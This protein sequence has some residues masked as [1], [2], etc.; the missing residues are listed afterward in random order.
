MLRFAEFCLVW[1]HFAIFCQVQLCFASLLSF[2]ALRSNL[3]R[4]ALF[5]RILLL[6]VSSLCSDW[7]HI[8]PSSSIVLQFVLLCF[9]FS[10]AILLKLLLSS[11]IYRI[12]SLHIVSLDLGL[13]ALF[14]CV[15]VK[16]LCFRFAL[17][18]SGLAYFAMFRSF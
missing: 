9:G 10:R 12:G 11:Y 6:H 4:F 16:E 2:A 8:T 15:W 13:F 17:L 3:H 18:C 5:L 14:C 7:L 1:P